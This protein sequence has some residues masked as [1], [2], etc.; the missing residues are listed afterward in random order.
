MRVDHF[1]LTFP[2]FVK[3]THNV[4]L[5][6]CTNR[7]NPNYSNENRIHVWPVFVKVCNLPHWLALKEWYIHIPIIIPNPKNP[8][9][10]LDVTLQP[11]NNELKMLFN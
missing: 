5:G 10:N 9:Q 8:G 1:D 6:L 11:L 2:Y 4:R 7:F 3:E